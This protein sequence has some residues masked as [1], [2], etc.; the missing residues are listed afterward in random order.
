MALF[1][2]LLFT[3][4]FISHFK[5]SEVSD[6][7]SIYPKEMTKGHL[8]RRID[9][10][11]NLTCVVVS[12][13]N[14]RSNDVKITWTTPS[15]SRNSQHRITYV[16]ERNKVILMV[17]KLQE[18]DSGEYKCQAVTG[19]DHSPLTE[20]VRVNVKKQ[21]KQRCTENFFQ[22][23]STG[24]CIPRIYLCDGTKDCKDGGDEAETIC[25]RD[26]CEG[27]I[28]CSNGRCIP[29]SWCC[30]EDMDP[31]CTVK[32]RHDCCPKLTAGDMDADHGYP[33]SDQ[34][35]FSDMGFLQTTIYTVIGCAM[36]FMF[37]VTI[38]VI[39]ICRVHM[40]RSLLSRCPGA[41][42]QTGRLG[43]RGG[44]HHHHAMQHVPLYD[45]DVFLNRP[46]MSPHSGLLVTYNINNGVQ[47]V[48]RPVD[49]PPYC[50]VV[51]APPREGPPPPYASH[52]SL[53]TPG[54]A[55]SEEPGES[56]SLLGASREESSS[57]C[58]N[59]SNNS[60]ISDTRFVA[61]DC[62]YSDSYGVR[63]NVCPDH[64]SSTNESANN[65]GAGNSSFENVIIPSTLL[66]IDS[67]NCG[68]VSENANEN[69]SVHDECR[70]LLSGS[71]PVSPKVHQSANVPNEI[72]NTSRQ[73]QS[74]FSL[75]MHVPNIEENSGD[76]NH[77]SHHPNIQDDPSAGMIKLAATESVTQC[78]NSGSDI[79]RTQISK[80]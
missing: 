14:T 2:L 61:A 21:K 76:E 64:H 63:E 20:V 9:D 16:E 27:K 53:V 71:L 28:K 22:C 73:P 69:T 11:L 77:D 59:S 10:T 32:I 30:Y 43:A 79:D 25:G 4:T 31:N 58:H 60:G 75:L 3:C 50:E 39:A 38:L 33:P 5:C 66:S 13:N 29:Y 6:V 44:P 68:R 46:D 55:V 34:Q 45:L 17:E 36:A 54:M 67:G 80:E 62:D 72:C 8:I 26:P 57:D 1:I 12:D 48:G 19:S 35:R 41:R 7:I 18:T 56:D 42:L 40:K 23:M 49:P 51:A 70:P 47:F 37:I 52:E 24:L 78:E 74:K 65:I 15:H